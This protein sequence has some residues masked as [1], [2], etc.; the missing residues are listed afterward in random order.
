VA[1]ADSPTPT[2]SGFVPDET[3]QTIVLELTV[4]DGLETSAPDQTR[5][6]VV[7]EIT[8]GHMSLRNPPFRDDLPTLVTFG[9]GNCTAGGPMPFSDPPQWYEEANVISGFYEPP[10]EDQANWLIVFLSAVAPT[11]DRQI[12][13]VGF[14][15]GGNPAITV[16][17][18]LN[19]TYGDPRYAVNRVTLLDATCPHPFASEVQEFNANP[20]GGEPAWVDTYRAGARFLPGALNVVF[21]FAPHAAPYDWFRRSIAPESQPTG[22][23]FHG[24]VTAGAYISVIGEARRLRL[25][26]NATPYVFE[27]SGDGIDCLTQRDIAEA[28]GRLPE[29]V[30]L[31]GPDDDAELPPAGASLS[32]ERSEN[33]VGYI[34]LTGPSPEQLSAVSAETDQPPTLHLTELPFQ[35]TYWTV[36]VRDAHGSTIEAAPRRLLP[37]RARPRHPA[38]RAAASH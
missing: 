9:G 10:Y 12:Q 16:A 4:D 17:N 21:P 31:V 38:G 3:V 2:I 14:S 27:C 19:S 15:T 22:G 32:C 28:P 8:V 37:H 20:V 34:L 7:P 36:R 35:P 25:A 29:P 6:T 18:H 26:T 30:R 11:Y 33:A 1:A 23:A 13:T 5:I 24:G